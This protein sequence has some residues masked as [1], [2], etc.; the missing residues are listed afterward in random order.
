[1]VA[2]TAPRRCDVS[3]THSGLSAGQRR[4]PQRLA[5][6]LVSGGQ[7]SLLAASVTGPLTR[8]GGGLQL[9]LTVTAKNTG[10]TP[11][12][13]TRAI[14]TFDLKSYG[15]NGSTACNGA[16]KSESKSM[17]TDVVFPGAALKQEIHA[18]ADPDELS[19]F[20][21]NDGSFRPTVTVCIDCRSALDESIHHQTF[22]AFDLFRMRS[23]PDG[24]LR[25]DP[26]DGDLAASE[27]DLSH[28][29][30]ENFAD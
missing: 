28:R 19:T 23:A 11:A 21:M 17:Q 13:Y 1:M 12:L 25:V 8:Q 27:I 4:L 30:G 2:D 10:L 22:M 14:A 5:T 7:P 16:R 3:H 29:W 24:R 15:P 18:K 26:K 9:E 6:W 20:R